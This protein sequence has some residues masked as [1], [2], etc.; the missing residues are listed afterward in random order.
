MKKNFCKN[1][2]SFLHKTTLS[3][4]LGFVFILA[5]YFCG[6][7]M[8]KKTK[9]TSNDSSSYLDNFSI[10]RRFKD[11]QRRNKIIFEQKCNQPL[12]NTNARRKINRVGF[13]LMGTGLYIRLVE[14]VIL[15]IDKHFCSSSLSSSHYVHY[16]VL[17]DAM[18]LNST[19][20]KHNFTIIH[21]P[22]L[23]W[24]FSTLSRFQHLHS[25]FYNKNASLLTSYDYLYWLDVDMRLVDDVCEDIFGDLVGVIH[26]QRDTSERSY[27]YESSNE[28]SSAYLSQENR[29][30][31][32]YYFGA[33]W[34]GRVEHVFQ[35]IMTCDENVKY[36]YEKLNGFVAHQHDESHL[37]RFDFDFKLP[38]IQDLFFFHPEW[39]KYPVK[40]IYH[41][42]FGGLV[43]LKCI[44]LYI[45]LGL[46]KSRFAKNPHM[47]IFGCI[48]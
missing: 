35:L 40:I 18:H 14:Q 7:F 30:E 33:F 32:P 9:I 8:F 42:Q 22:H 48:K 31:N 47:A 29:Y 27:P 37:N 44:I 28:E 6:E 20:F 46:I 1:K 26:P 41:S 24:P 5:F 39:I 2:K 3:L 45:F 23:A 4:T 12:S 17:T 19:L 10:L 13:F 15:S 38:K 11:K 25:L 21:T 36:D 34:G 43:H 16:F